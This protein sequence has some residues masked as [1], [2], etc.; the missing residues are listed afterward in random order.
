MNS[1]VKLSDMLFYVYQCP[2]LDNYLEVK[3]LIVDIIN[4][5]TISYSCD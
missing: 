3:W 5:G 2:S 4:C 1:A